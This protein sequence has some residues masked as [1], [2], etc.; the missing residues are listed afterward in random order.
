MMEIN[1]GGWW[2]LGE[3]MMFLVSNDN[4]LLPFKHHQLDLFRI[5][6]Y[7]H[8]WPL[9]G[10]IPRGWIFST[11]DKPLQGRNTKG[12]SNLRI[13]AVFSL[14]SHSALTLIFATHHMSLRDMNTMGNSYSYNNLKIEVRRV[15]YYVPLEHLVGRITV[16]PAWPS[17]GWFDENVQVRIRL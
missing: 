16:S 5:K 12:N 15:L 7:L 3:G 4:T 2:E 8:D 11:H 14:F 1:G 6:K 9:Q 13:A 17:V 10:R